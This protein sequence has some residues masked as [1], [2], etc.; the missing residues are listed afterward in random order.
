MRT[1]SNDKRFKDMEEQTNI[2]QNMTIEEAN[3]LPTILQKR[4]FVDYYNHSHGA[5][6]LF[7]KDGQIK[8]VSPSG[9]W[10]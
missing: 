10:Y 3:K 5:N 7:I 1:N 4:E 9:W 8:K 2:Y 6:L